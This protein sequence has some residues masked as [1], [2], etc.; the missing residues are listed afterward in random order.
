MHEGTSFFFLKLSRPA[1]L[2]SCNQYSFHFAR[3]QLVHGMLDDDVA[4]WMCFFVETQTTKSKVTGYEQ[5]RVGEGES[6]EN[7]ELE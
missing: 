2:T 5:E 4:C 3:P 1:L 7:G 6:K